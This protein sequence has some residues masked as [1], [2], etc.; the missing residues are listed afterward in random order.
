M[1]ETIYIQEDGEMREATQAELAQLEIDREA[2]ELR[3]IEQEAKEAARQ[4]ALAKLAALGLT[5]EEIA[6]L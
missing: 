3:L 4:S 2:E 5:E 1:S 6:A